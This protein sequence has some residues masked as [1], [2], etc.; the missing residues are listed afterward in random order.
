MVFVEE[1]NVW[2]GETEK[3][4]VFL[5]VVDIIHAIENRDRIKSWRKV[6][7]LS[8]RLLKKQHCSA[9]RFS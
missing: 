2:I 7:L 4:I 5:H 9:H 8:A 1:F 6:A 3:Q